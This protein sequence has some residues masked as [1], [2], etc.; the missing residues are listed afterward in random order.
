[1]SALERDLPHLADLRLK[2]ENAAYG[3]A[4]YKPKRSRWAQFS[5]LARRNMLFSICLV[6]PVFFASIYYIFIA[7]DIY[8]SEAFFIVR[9]SSSA[10][11][12]GLGGATG[13]AGQVGSLLRTDDDTQAVN[14]YMASRDALDRLI[15]ESNFLDIVNRP[16]AD[17]LARF[18]RFWSGANREAFFRRLSEYIETSFDDD[19]GVT[20]LTV[21]AFR[22][23][24]ARDIAVVLLSHGEELVNR[25]SQRSRNDAIA[26]AEEVAT[27][28]EAKV[29]EAQERIT[30]FRNQKAVFDPVREAGAGL[31]LVAKLNTDIAELKATLAEL[32]AN[33]PENPSVISARSRVKALEEQVAEQRTLIAGGEHSLAPKVAEYEKLTLER[34][35][36][37]KSF[38]SSLVSLE[39]ARED[40]RRQQLYLERIVEPNLPDH[41]RYPRR[42]LS[43]LGVAAVSLVIYWILSV[44]GGVVL[45]HD[46]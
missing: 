9:S 43:I 6:L 31:E 24:D 16:E 46:I 42:F 44:L 38:A 26:F 13:A 28:F 20:T 22:P 4:Q 37:A 45:E 10:P 33:S 35:L 21:R 14:T 11:K 17:F 19:A 41:P 2:E 12:V 15:R 18:P 29:K 34:D 32:R 39:S 36:A 5:E 8:V 27:E 7:A 25:M 1:M 30:A 40:G 23:E 3:Y